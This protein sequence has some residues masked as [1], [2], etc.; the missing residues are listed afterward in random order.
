MPSKAPVPSF[1][2]FTF[3]RGKSALTAAQRAGFK[4]QLR[5][6]LVA[7]G[8]PTADIVNISL[9]EAATEACNDDSP[10]ALRATIEYAHHTCIARSCAMA[11]EFVVTTAAGP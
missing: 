10:H 9:T 2:A 5:S 4:R 1:L 3:S 6:A 11:N 7:R 8:V